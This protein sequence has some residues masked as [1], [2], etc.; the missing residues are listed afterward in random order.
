MSTFNLGCLLLQL[1]IKITVSA[2]GDL[3]P[4]FFQHILSKLLLGGKIGGGN[5]IYIT[6]S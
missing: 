4:S 5:A 6:S 3:G 2:T 1:Q